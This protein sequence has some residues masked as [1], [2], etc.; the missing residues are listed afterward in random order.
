ML[1]SAATG[2]PPRGLLERMFPEEDGNR[3]KVEHAGP[4][5]LDI[6]CLFDAA[7]ADN[8]CDRE[9]S[10][11]LIWKLPAGEPCCVTQ[12]QDSMR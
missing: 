11:G 12:D 8:R 10:Q 1:V 2:R 7:E 6:Q 9:V 3:T 5:G 4:G